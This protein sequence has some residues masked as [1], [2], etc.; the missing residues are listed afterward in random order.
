MEMPTITPAVEALEKSTKNK[1]RIEEENEKKE[2]ERKAEELRKAAEM[3][4]CVN[5]ELTRTIENGK[6]TLRFDISKS[7]H[8][9]PDIKAKFDNG[10]TLRN[11]PDD[12]HVGI[13][14]IELEKSGYKVSYGRNSDGVYVLDICWESCYVKK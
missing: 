14:K 12:S 10:D 8:T 1:K 9:D 13:V 6:F 7:V 11:F 4:S 3:L 2:S 5:P